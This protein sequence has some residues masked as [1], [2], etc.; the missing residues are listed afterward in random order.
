[1]EERIALAET[2]PVNLGPTEAPYRLEDVSKIL[3]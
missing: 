2:S 3:H 1:M